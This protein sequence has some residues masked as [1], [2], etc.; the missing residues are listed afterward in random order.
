VVLADHGEAF[1]E[2]GT[3]FHSKTLYQELIH[4][5][6]IFYGPG[7]AAK[8]HD[9]W[10]SLIDVAPTLLA[11]Y[12]QAVPPFMMGESLLPSLVGQPQPPRVRPIAAEGRQRRALVLQEGLKAIE[13]RRHKTIE[14]YDLV[15]DPEELVDLVKQDPVRAAEAL[16]ALRSFFAQYAAER[17]GYRPPYKR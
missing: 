12:G 17:D 2:H 3:T 16:S 8:R 11:L 14:A 4:V 6:L 15:R 5:P 13:D 7:I 10:V 1:G 9:E